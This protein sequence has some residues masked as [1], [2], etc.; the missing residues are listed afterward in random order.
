MVDWQA[1]IEEPSVQA[2]VVLAIGLIIG[3]LV[4]RLNRR[5]LQAA[6]IPELVEGTAFERTA[7]SLGTST[8]GIVARISSW[9][10]YG[11]A[12]LTAVYVA[13]LVSGQ[14]FWVR[15]T[16]FLPDLFIAVLVLVVGFVVADKAEL[17]VSE[18]MRGVKLPEVAFIPKIAKYSILYIAFLVALAQVGVSTTALHVLFAA[19]L[20]GVIVIGGI[21]FRHMLQSAASGIYVLLRQPY[22]IGDE[23]RIGDRQGIVQGVELF[24]TRIE[25]DGT[26]YVIPNH[27]VFE[28]GVARVRD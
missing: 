21:A 16:A 7:E 4:G 3:L 12:V 11:V 14:V 17:L 19:Y 26:E 8:V 25:D 28:H 6:G 5:V 15:I 13:R 2:V 27:E 23:I 9:F 24:T 18:R 22:G 1:L 10:I 20:F